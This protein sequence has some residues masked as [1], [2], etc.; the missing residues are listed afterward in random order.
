MISE[1]MKQK[2]VG[3]SA[4]RKMFDEGRE[5]AAKYGAE[6]VYDFSIGNPI[7]PPPDSL[8]ETVA[9][10][11]EESKPV[12]IHGYMNNSGYFDVREKLAKYENETKGT[13]LTK[14]QIIM[15]CGAAGGLNV[16]MRCLLNP[17]D[18]V[19]T[20]APFFTE[21]RNYVS[22]YGG[23]LTVVPPNPPSFQPDMVAFE[24]AI[25][26]K[27]KAV[28]INSP[29]NPTG[30]VYSEATYESLSEILRKKEKEYGQSIVLISDEPYREIAYVEGK[31]PYLLNYYDNSM[32]VYSYSKSLSLPG[33]RVGYISVNP[34]IE[35]LENLLIALNLA[36][37]MLGFVNS[38][39]LF[40][41]VVAELAG[42]TVNVDFYKR[43]R[44]AL[45]EIL[46]EVG[47]EYAPADGTFYL[48]VK[49][50][51]EDEVAFCTKA[52]EYNLLLVAASGFGCPGYFRM[53]YC[54]PYE[55]VL[56]S[57]D[58]IRKLMSNYK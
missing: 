57:F 19:L 14:E 56:G 55:N 44:D 29:N 50:P 23:V 2:S 33:E 35:A 15:T 7:V 36:N 31:I 46:D 53:A 40:Q 4:I 13:S 12:D 51:I 11:L 34:K 37:R 6:N 26:D 18:E 9:R 39:S 1:Y 25:T 32:V 17:G 8:N 52:K 16:I 49:A 48:F 58:A 28:I 38:P 41:K 22:N 10:I 27:T 20:I 42:N 43:N 21:Y 5:M 47:L 45:I 3:S 54:I 24:A 30:V